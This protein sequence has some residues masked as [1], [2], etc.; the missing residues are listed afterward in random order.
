VPIDDTNDFMR[1]TKMTQEH[2]YESALEE[3]EK[4]INIPSKNGLEFSGFYY[5]ETIQSALEKA[6]KYDALIERLRGDK[7][8][9]NRDLDIILLVSKK[10]PD[11]CETISNRI[12]RIRKATPAQL[13]KEVEWAISK[14]KKRQSPKNRL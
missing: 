6:Q 14:K 2:D 8:D 12:E 11:Y 4:A 1:R 3:F 9:Y 7:T 13:L 5:R 10:S